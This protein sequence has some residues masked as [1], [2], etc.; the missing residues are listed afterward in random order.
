[1]S[2]QPLSDIRVIDLTQYI[3]GP[4][5]TKLLADFGADVI[6]IERPGGGDLARRL[7]PFPGDVPHSE[8]SGLF[9]HL[10][11]NKRS[12][13]LNLKTSEG[14]DVLRSLLS[15][16]DILVESF[17]PGEMAR[18]GLDPAD[19]QQTYP[20]LVITSISNFGQTGPYRDYKASEITLFA[21]GGRMSRSG[22]P[23]RY[24][25]KLGGNHVQYQAGNCAAM[26]TLFAWYAGR[27]K[28]IGGQHVDIAIFETQLA[29]YNSRMPYLLAYAYTGER[30]T[31]G[32]PGGGGYP[33]GYYPCADGYIHIT[34]GGAFFPRSAALLGR[35]ELATDPRFAP[36]LGQLNRQSKEEFE[37]T[38]WLP[39]LL[40][41][42]RSEVVETAQSYELLCGAV[43]SIDE[44]VQ[45]PQL[46]AREY[47]VDI[48]HPVSG[49]FRYP[50]APIMPSE[51][52]WRLRRPAPLLGQHTGEVLTELL[53]AS[54]EELARLEER[55]VITSS[56]YS[57]ERVSL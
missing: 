34:G 18:L 44:V 41:R 49:T 43:Y 2:D 1:M 23:D 51:P 45:N 26:A 55:G 14:T 48:D 11:T 42:T 31:R 16:A 21:M 38:L 10:N 3:A 36:P 29:S 53:G 22:L 56:A 5:C 20:N 40:E 27:Y 17:R 8:K 12:V 39:W 25:L 37:I 33:S 35:P 54:A 19:L 4:Y 46:T 13:V 32:E 50:G 7:G 6:K 28:G 30:G 52:W 57:N 9:L 15:G 24:P 47:F